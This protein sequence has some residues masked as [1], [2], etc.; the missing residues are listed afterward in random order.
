MEL[1]NRR[2]LLLLVNNLPPKAYTSLKSENDTIW[3][4]IHAALGSACQP[5]PGT[6]INLPGILGAKGMSVELPDERMF[7]NDQAGRLFQAV[8]ETGQEMASMFNGQST[9]LEGLSKQVAQ[10]QN[11]NK[12][13]QNNLTA[14]GG[15]FTDVISQNPSMRAFFLE[16]ID[17]SVDMRYRNTATF[18]RD[19]RFGGPATKAENDAYDVS[20]AAARIRTINN[21]N[22]GGDLETDYN[23]WTVGLVRQRHPDAESSTV[24]ELGFQRMYGG[25]TLQAAGFLGM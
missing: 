25:L 10:L 12:L 23:L 3:Q 9:Q 16:M 11:E 18:L 22:H 14:A 4:P 21:M 6:F 19:A 7:G 17:R 1:E 8:T 2:N 24:F 5:V 20:F 15:K 13:L